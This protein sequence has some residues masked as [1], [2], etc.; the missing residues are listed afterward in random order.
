MGV[1]RRE[2]RG[3]PGGARG[4]GLDTIVVRGLASGTA[5]ALGGVAEAAAPGA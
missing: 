3:G 5:E 2:R 4:Y 1:G